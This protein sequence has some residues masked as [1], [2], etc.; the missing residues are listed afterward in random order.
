MGRI[1]ERIFA[2]QVRGQWIRVRQYRGS[3]GERHQ[4]SLGAITAEEAR[5]LNDGGGIRTFDADETDESGQPNEESINDQGREWFNARR[6][7]AMDK[8]KGACEYL[9]WGDAVP[10]GRDISMTLI[11]AIN[12]LDMAASFL[13]DHVHTRNS[14]RF[15]AETGRVSITVRNYT[16]LVSELFP[17]LA[18][19]DGDGDPA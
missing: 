10:S 6:Q 16:R 14:D 2:R 12:R 18:E 9:G 8:T 13:A 3:D 19:D 7:D 17:T 15:A 11:D 1:R 5:K 4:Q